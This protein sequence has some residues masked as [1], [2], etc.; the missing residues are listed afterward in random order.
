MKYLRG[1]VKYFLILLSLFSIEFALAKETQTIYLEKM[2]IVTF[3]GDDG[4]WDPSIPSISIT[5][6][7]RA[8]DILSEYVSFNNENGFI[9]FTGECSN[10]NYDIEW[11]KNLFLGTI[12]KSQ[13]RTNLPKGQYSSQTFCLRSRNPRNM[14]QVAAAAST[15]KINIVLNKDETINCKDRDMSPVRFSIHLSEKN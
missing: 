3:E 13:V 4:G 8:L 12:M 14:A 15:M 6:C 5:R 9:S 7:R 2:R 10:D 11:P 1:F